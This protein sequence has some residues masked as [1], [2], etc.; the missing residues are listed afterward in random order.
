MPAPKK[1]SGLATQLA[2]IAG[3]LVFFAFCMH[4]VVFIL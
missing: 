3:S 1:T 2:V 4:Y